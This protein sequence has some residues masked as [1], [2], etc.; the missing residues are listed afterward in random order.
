MTR[1][2]T[3]TPASHHTRPSTTLLTTSLY[4]SS[5]PVLFIFPSLPPVPP[6]L[7][8][9]PSLSPSPTLPP[10]ASIRGVSP[11]FGFGVYCFRWCN[12]KL[13]GTVWS[14][15][16]FGSLLLVVSPILG[17]LLPFCF[18][19]IRLVSLPS[20]LPHCVVGFQVF[21]H[22]CYRSLVLYIVPK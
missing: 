3:M 9:H 13:Y 19:N 18:F 10:S 22:Y 15:C 8:Q 2:T 16:V 11:L 12:Q 5:F 1:H 6:P 4:S 14:S 17:V 7:L 21:I 20:S